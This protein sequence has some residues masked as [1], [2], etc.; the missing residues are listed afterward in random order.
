MLKISNLKIPYEVGDS[1]LKDKIASF[2]NVPKD[3]INS[4]KILKKSTDARHKPDIFFIERTKS[5]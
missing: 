3:H 5:I 1:G 2:L 4:I